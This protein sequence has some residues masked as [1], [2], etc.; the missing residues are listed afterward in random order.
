MNNDFKQKLQEREF[1]ALK[2]ESRVILKW[3]TGCGKSKMVIDLINHAVIKATVGKIVPRRILFVVAERAHINNWKEEFKKWNLRFDKVLPDICCYASL[4]KYIEYKYDIVVF[5]E[6]HHAFTEKRLAALEELKDNLYPDAHIYLLSATLSSG[7]QDMIEGIFGKFKTSTVTLKDAIEGDILPDPKVYVI[8]MELDNVK[9]H[10][11]I[12]IGNDPK[13]PIVKWEDRAKY[14]YKNTPCIIQCTE[15][16]KNA[17]LTANMEYWKQRYER[18]HN[19]FQRTKWVNLG[20][21]RKRFLGELKTGAIRKLI[22]RLP[23]NNRFVCF[24][25]S[26]DQANNLDYVNTISSKRPAKSNQLIID[27]FN[28]K[29]INHIYAVG[30]ITEGMNLTDIQTGIIVQLDG[31]ERLFIQKF[32]RSLRAEDPVTFIFYYKDTQDEKYLKGALENIDAK[33]VQHININ[34]LNN[35]KL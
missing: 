12:K 27:K 34:Q 30:M 32:G 24:C 29:E 13:A 7:K 14:I 21:Q 8:G 22:E 11:E 17:Y 5:D 2:D 31:K 28:N 4:K 10:Q 20:G 25:A 9:K 33:Y 26:V 23:K 15:F 18:S 35:I 1:L 19:E 6:A 16:Q 3:A